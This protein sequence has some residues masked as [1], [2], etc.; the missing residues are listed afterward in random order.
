MQYLSEMTEDQ[1]NVFW[2]PDGLIPSHKEALRVVVTNGMVIPNYSQ[3][4]DLKMNATVSQY[5]QMTAEVI[6]T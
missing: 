2:S 4:D 6:C 5:G 1:T 3:P